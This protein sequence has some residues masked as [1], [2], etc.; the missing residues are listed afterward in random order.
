MDSTYSVL[1]LCRKKLDFLSRIGKALAASIA[2]AP[3]LPFGSTIVREDFIEPSKVPQTKELPGYS[4]QFA[5]AKVRNIP[6]GE[7]RLDSPGYP[8]TLFLRC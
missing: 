1:A 3:C 6:Y 8:H 4:S 2:K 5:S 7:R